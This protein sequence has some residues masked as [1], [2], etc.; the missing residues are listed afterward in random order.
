MTNLLTWDFWFNLNPGALTPLNQK[1]FIGLIIAF[2]AL[3]IFVLIIKRNGGIYRG[4]LNSLYSFYL[5]NAIIGSIIFFFNYELVPFF[6]ARFW[7]AIWLIAMLAWLVFILKRLSVIP[8][9]KKELEEAKEI[10]KYLP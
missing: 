7:L 4:F 6:S 5:G 3:T 10:N 1:I 8:K 9:H 2:V